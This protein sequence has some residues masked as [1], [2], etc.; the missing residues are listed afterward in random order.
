VGS[1]LKKDAMK[2]SVTHG[3]ALR[4]DTPLLALGT[5]EGESL[6]REVASLLEDGDWSGKWKQTLVLYPRGA[7][8][9]RRLLLVG[10]GKRAQISADRLREA[11]A[12]AGRRARELRVERYMFGLPTVEGLML[13]AGAQAL[14]EG[15]LLGLYRF[16]EFKTGLGPD[17][18]QELAEL[19]IISA[20]ED[21][22]IKQG[23]AA[24]EAIAHGVA[25]ARDLSNRPGNDLTPTKLAETAQAIGARFGMQVTVFGAE[26]L[27][28]QGFGG[29]LGVAQG[30][31]QP[32]R[33]IIMEHGATLTNAPTICLV[34]KGITFDSGGISIK[35]AERMEEMK[36]DMGGAA[37]VL[38]AMHVVGELNLPL[39]VV[40]LIAAAENLPSGTAYKPGDVLKTLSGKTV[41]VVN[42]DAEGRIVLADALFYAQ[43]YQPHGIIDLATL[44]GAV[45]VA[46]GAHAIGAMGN[47]DA[48]AE[49]IVRAGEASSEPAWRLPLWEP[50]KEMVKSDI[51]DIKNSAGRYAG[52]ITAGAFLA[53]FVGDYPWVHLDIAG[54]A[55]L[56]QKKAYIPKG[57]NGSGVRL[58]VQTLRTWVE[59]R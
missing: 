25:A 30:S 7:L 55:L 8:P 58:L 43:R 52:S 34:G 6:P 24:G 44:T 15:S 47:D 26:E 57:A 21:D 18:E 11:G 39:H 28:E 9:A 32:P 5:W 20:I 16:Q 48:L 23:A 50:Y 10:L 45:M 53:N 35:P 31:S 41:E 40:G 14:V 3:E 19:T 12:L 4:Q 37:A 59:D 54:T 29:L 38:G 1:A 22:T 27:R 17:D 36:M 13:R 51:A 2:I 49:R 42:T 33:F 56:D 46:L